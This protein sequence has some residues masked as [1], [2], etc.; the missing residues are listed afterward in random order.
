MERGE[1]VALPP[2]R[3]ER[4]NKCGPVR[5]APSVDR[6]G[7]CAVGRRPPH[8]ESSMFE[9]FGVIAFAAVS[10]GVAAPAHAATAANS[11]NGTQSS[12]AAKEMAPGATEMAPDPATPGVVQVPVVVVPAPVVV[13][14]APVVVVPSTGAAVAPAQ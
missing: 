1:A 7:A 13:T 8:R 6:D 10:L 14:P 9:K 5:F 2:A 3:T 12:S 11:Q 4:V